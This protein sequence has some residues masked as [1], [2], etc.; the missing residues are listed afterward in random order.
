[1][2]KDFTICTVPSTMDVSLGCSVNINVYSMLSKNSFAAHFQLFS[3]YINVFVS[4]SIQ[5][6]L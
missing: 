6:A 2:W 3:V 1:M 5:K 4:D